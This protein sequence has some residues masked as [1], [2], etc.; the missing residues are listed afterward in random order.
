MKR[1]RWTN[2]TPY[3]QEN[4]TVRLSLSGKTAQEAVKIVDQLYLTSPDN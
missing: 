1:G 2:K 3:A 4:L